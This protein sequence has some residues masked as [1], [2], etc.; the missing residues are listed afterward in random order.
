[1]LNLIRRHPSEDRDHY[2]VLLSLARGYL[3]SIRSNPPSEPL[4]HS[5]AAIA[6]DIHITRKLSNFMPLKPHHLPPQDFAWN[7][8]AD[9]LDGWADICKV[10]AVASLTTWKVRRKNLISCSQSNY[11]RRLPETFPQISHVLLGDLRF[12]VL[13]RRSVPEITTSAGIH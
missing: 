3:Q 10:S 8:L 4:P 9:M 5:P 11:F 2:V 7:A 1:M 6:F 12:S 13:L